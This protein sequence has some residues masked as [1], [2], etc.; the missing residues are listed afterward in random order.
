VANQRHHSYCKAWALYAASKEPCGCLTALR[1][2]I[3]GRLKSGFKDVG[4]KS[5]LLTR[6]V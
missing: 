2:G 5:I 1:R 6:G 4:G 3:G